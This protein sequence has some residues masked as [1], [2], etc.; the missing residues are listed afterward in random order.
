MKIN[1]RLSAVLCVSA[2]LHGQILFFVSLP[3]TGEKAPENAS[4]KTFSLVNIERKPEAHPPVQKAQPKKQP[5]K[6]EVP[7]AL[8]QEISD[9]GVVQETETEIL[10]PQLPVAYSPQEA[11]SALA[12]YAGRIRS[13]IDKNKEYPYQARRQEQEGVVRVRFTL[14]KNGFLSGDPVLAESCRHARLN[15]AAIEAVRKA[16]P[17]PPFP[18]Q[19]RDET[20]SFTIDVVFSLKNR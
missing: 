6:A 14:A 11:E 1:K 15:A 5:Q 19:L 16:Q 17:Y 18:P 10:A 8:E 12:D 13:R 9:D 2:L 20:M 7:L 4:A 3:R